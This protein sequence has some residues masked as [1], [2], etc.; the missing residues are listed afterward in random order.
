MDRLTRRLVLLVAL[1]LPAGACS[2]SDT[3]T[4]TTSPTPTTFTDTFSGTLNQNGAGTYPFTVQTAGTV[5]ATLT[6]IGQDSAPKIGVSLGTWN[7]TSCQTVIAN[8]GA[9]V[10]AQVIGSVTS[11]GLL[12]VRVYDIGNVNDPLTYTV[13]V[14]HP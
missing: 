6:A 12:C 8:D 5:T 10:G 1:C 14:V 7:G 13:Q 3:P 2:S 4:T 9:T 11:A